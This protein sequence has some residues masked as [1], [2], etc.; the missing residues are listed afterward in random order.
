MQRLVTLDTWGTV[1][2]VDVDDSSAPLTPEARAE[3]AEFTTVFCQWVDD[4][5][6]PFREDSLV[7]RIRRG[8]LHF[9]DLDD[10]DPD[11]ATLAMIAA[12]CFEG[13]IMTKGAFNPWAPDGGFDPSGV[14]KGWAAQE[15]CAYL[16]DDG[17]ENVCVN[18]GGDIAVHGT[19]DGHP[20]TVGVI[21]P[22]TPGRIVHHFSRDDGAVA[23]SSPG[24][25]GDH[26]RDPFTRDVARGARSVSVAGPDAATAEILAIAVLVAGD[27]STDWMAQFPGYEVFAVEPLPV[28]SA[29]TIHMA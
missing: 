19:V 29:W 27:S 4:V 14:V 22:S 8:E 3:A 10:S 20:W 18:A 9:T 25:R 12:R 6:S 23:T 13:R 7:S 24:E 28:E 15:L 1:L 21:D 26:I 17:L 16:V 2:T 11:H 5:F